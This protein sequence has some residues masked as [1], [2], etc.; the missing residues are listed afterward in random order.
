MVGEA[1][2]SIVGVVTYMVSRTTDTL[3]AFLPLPNVPPIC[4]L[5]Q[6]ES[7]AC[8]KLVSSKGK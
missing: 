6:Y 2:S 5:K 7:F 3:L 8:W 4:Y 1:E